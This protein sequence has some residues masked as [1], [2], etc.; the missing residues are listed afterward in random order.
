M[1][2]LNKEQKKEYKRLHKNMRDIIREY[3]KF[4]NNSTLPMS[5]IK[6]S[7]FI[8]FN[9]DGKLVIIKVCDSDDYRLI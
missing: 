5:R 9:G 3:V 1:G 7:D 2:A 4:C 6:K 8:T